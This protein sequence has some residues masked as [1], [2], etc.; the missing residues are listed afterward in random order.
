[1]KKFYTGLST[2]LIAIAVNGQWVH[3]SPA[4]LLTPDTNTSAS[5]TTTNIT[6]QKLTWLHGSWSASNEKQTIDEHWSLQGESLLGISRT[7]E[8]GKSRAFELLL[9]EKQGDDFILRLRFFGPAIDKATRGKEEP[10]RLKVVQ[11]DELGLRCEGI[12]SETGT[13]L[14]YTK[15]SANTMQAQISKVRE[16]KLVWQETYQFRRSAQ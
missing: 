5:Q 3:A 2:I 13:T 15:L 14:L 1:M 8:A 7:M 4:T 16:G 10:L 11:A 9:I 6:L 12:D